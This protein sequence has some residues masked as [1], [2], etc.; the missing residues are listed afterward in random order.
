MFAARIGFFNQGS[1]ADVTGGNSTTDGA[2]TV[3]TFTS[4]GTLSV[5]NATVNM[6]Y[7][8][9]GAGGLGNSNYGGGGGA[10]V[11]QGTFTAG[12]TYTITIGDG[13][14]GNG[15]STISTVVSANKGGD[16][17]T[18]GRNGGNSGSYFGGTGFIGGAFTAGGGGAGFGANGDNA[19]SG[20]GGNGGDGIMSNISGSN[21]YYAGGGG[22]G[23]ISGFGTGG[24]GGGGNGGRTGSGADCANGAPNSGG[25]GGS[26]N[27]KSANGYGGSGITIVR[28]LTPF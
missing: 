8:V 22:G 18:S 25:G 26:D 5:S 11:A 14:T 9:V 3:R 15:I 2:Y 4:N 27:G 17:P 24:L 21:V 16:Q 23:S 20:F 6:T 13:V 28:Y 10:N 1:S 12:G 7:L 19:T